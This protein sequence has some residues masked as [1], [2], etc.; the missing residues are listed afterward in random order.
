MRVIVLFSMTLTTKLYSGL[1]C[2]LKMQLTENI[3]A[4]EKIPMKPVIFWMCRQSKISNSAWAVAIAR[5]VTKRCRLSWQTNS[6]LVY[7]PKFGGRGR[8]S[9][10]ANEY[11]CT[12]GA[13]I[14]FGDLTPYLTYDSS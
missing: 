11:S 9:A 10:S 6:A 5:G 8:V 3:L 12:H 2:Q 14:K 13:Q 7:E 1:S 4:L